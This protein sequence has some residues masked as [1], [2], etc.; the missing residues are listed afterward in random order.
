MLKERAICRNCDVDIILT[1]AR[2][3]N[4]I[5]DQVNLASPGGISGGWW[6][7]D[8][9]FSSCACWYGVG[10]SK[11][12]LR[13]PKRGSFAGLDVDS[14]DKPLPLLWDA[15]G[16]FLNARL[17]SE[18]RL[19]G[20]AGT[21][22]VP[23]DFWRIRCLV[24]KALPL[25]TMRGSISKSFTFG[26]DFHE[27]L[28]GGTLTTLTWAGEEVAENKDEGDDGASLMVSEA[29]DEVID[30]PGRDGS[31]LDSLRGCCRSAS[32]DYVLAIMSKWQFNSPHQHTHIIVAQY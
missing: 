32:S 5:Y 2:R 24:S 23:P 3:K 19:G 17:A 26:W 31:D 27:D 28:G 21:L 7:F 14:A 9:G 11:K 22:D 1:S 16:T 20:G 15:I 6:G 13:S 29:W 30:G 4:R 25:D 12:S 10:R 8:S 18:L